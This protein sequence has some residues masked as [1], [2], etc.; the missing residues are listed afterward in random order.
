MP[1][2]F[3]KGKSGPIKTETEINYDPQRGGQ[4]VERW[5]SVGDQLRDIAAQYEALRTSY[6]LTPSTHKSSLIATSGSNND[7]PEI[8]DVEIDTWEVLANEI[9]KDLFEIPAARALD[10]ATV[11]RMRAGL[12]NDTAP[13][14]VT[15]AI[16][17]NALTIYSLYQKGTTHYARSQYVLRHTT[18]VS[19]R[20]NINI[21]D[22]NVD[23]IYTTTQLL[24]EVANPATWVYPLPPRLIFKIQAIPAPGAVSGFVWG[25]RKLAST[26]GTAANGRINISTE[27]WLEQWSCPFI[28]AAAS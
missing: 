27:Y 6:T 3:A 26:E 20:Y 17:G 18:N 24:T 25:W 9:E 22:V 28:Y 8:P 15:P 11:A 4:V 14:S 5:E 19:P 1:K 13:A 21:S 16:T 12:A 10:A 2:Q 7:N 23:C